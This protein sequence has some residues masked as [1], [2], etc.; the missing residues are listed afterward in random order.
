MHRDPGTAPVRPR[1]ERLRART[2][3]RTGI[4]TRSAAR[5]ASRVAWLRLP[6]SE[7]RVV[8]ALDVGHRE[9]P[10]VPVH[11]AARRIRG[12][13]C[14]RQRQVETPHVPEAMPLEE[15]LATTF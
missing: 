3:S 13:H 1:V 12:S 9:T 10:D 15:E 7:V 14:R 2:R 6:T 8:V 4:A 5:V 11:P